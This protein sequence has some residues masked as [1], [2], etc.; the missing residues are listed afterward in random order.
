MLFFLV[1]FNSTYTYLVFSTE[2]IP[3]LGT[4]GDIKKIYSFLQGA[5]T[6][7]NGSSVDINLVNDDVIHWEHCMWVIVDTGFRRMSPE[8]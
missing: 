4:A 5:R 3:Y 6:D 2:E 7:R 1:Y 8:S